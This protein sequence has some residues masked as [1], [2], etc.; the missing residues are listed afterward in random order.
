MSCHQLIFRLVPGIKLGLNHTFNVIT[1]GLMSPDGLACDWVTKKVYWADSET[2]RIEVS[3][4]DGT[5]RSVLFWR[6]LDQPR[7]IVLVPSDG[8]VLLLFRKF[9]ILFIILLK[10][11]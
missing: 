7:A 2:N 8:L 1:S 6:D 5:F 11:V 3:M 9:K 4:Y 10:T